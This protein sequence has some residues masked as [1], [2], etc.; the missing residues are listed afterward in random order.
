MAEEGFGAMSA[1]S[2]EP[3][4]SATVEGHSFS[5]PVRICGLGVFLLIP[6]FAWIW[7]DD[8]Q[9]VE[10]VVD[11]PEMFMAIVTVGMVLLGI[12]GSL[13]N[14][15]KTRVTADAI[16]WGIICRHHLPLSEISFVESVSNY[17]SVTVLDL[18]GKDGKTYEVYGG[19]AALRWTF[20]TLQRRCPGML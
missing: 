4:Y 7:I 10:G 5:L 17:L 8:P 14:F 18:R 15:S 1:T 6:M 13:I 12:W 19:T 2:S 20:L 11:G 3:D 16:E 9:F